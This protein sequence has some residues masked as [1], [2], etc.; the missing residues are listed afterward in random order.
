MLWKPG[1]ILTSTS[2]NASD[3]GEANA[4]Q[5]WRVSNVRGVRAG[6]STG[7]RTEE[8]MRSRTQTV[9]AAGAS[10]E[11]SITRWVDSCHCESVVGRSPPP[12]TALHVNVAIVSGD[13][14]IALHPELQDATPTTIQQDATSVKMTLRA[15]HSC[16]IVRRCRGMKRQSPPHARRR[17]LRC[18]RDNTCGAMA[19]SPGYA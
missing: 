15:Q 9:L 1:L 5:T 6:R 8:E 19:R 18:V 3:T 11:F 17:A 14:V 4:G 13:S 2:G 12:Q 7:G 10:A 16:C